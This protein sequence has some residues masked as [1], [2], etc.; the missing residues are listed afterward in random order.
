[1]QRWSDEFPVKGNHLY[2]NHAAMAP[3]PKRA[4]AKM[5]LFIGESQNHGRTVFPQWEAEA[6]ITRERLA[7]LVGSNPNEIAFTQNTTTG[8]LLIAQNFDFKAGDNI[9]VADLEHSANFYPWLMQRRRGVEVRILQSRDGIISCQD[10]EAI[11]DKGTRLVALSFVEF[12]NGFRNDLAAIG[13]LCHRHGAYLFVD[14]IQGLGALRFKVNELGVDFFAAGGYKWLM[15]PVGTGCLY[16]REDLLHFIS[17]PGGGWR[18]LGLGPQ[19]VSPNYIDGPPPSVRR[20]EEGMPNV[21]GLVGLGVALELILEVGIDNIE[22]QVMQLSHHLVE[23]LERK[24]Y[25]VTSPRGVGEGSQIISFGSRQHTS[26][27]LYDHLTDR[28]V[29]TALRGGF[30]RVSPHFYNTLEE[31]DRFIE[32]LP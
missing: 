24:G 2:L 22:R 13:D 25:T 12:S 31:M 10:V 1:M 6:E 28:G 16:C 7:L 30:I 15:G 5:Q 14:A 23:G 8:I 17:T 29:V 3:L 21:L 19:A 4:A 26:Q 9:I 20:L 11:I 32:L 27:E 18:Y